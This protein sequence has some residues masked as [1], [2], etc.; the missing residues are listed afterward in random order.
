MSY[1]PAN[2]KDLK[3]AVY[4]P[5]DPTKEER[6]FQI[7]VLTNYIETPDTRGSASTTD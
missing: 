2:V 7:K 6:V 5:I 3:D 4:F 1:S